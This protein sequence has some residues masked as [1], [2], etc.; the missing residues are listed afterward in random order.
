M[1]IG[2]EINGKL[3]HQPIGQVPLLEQK[4]VG[5]ATAVPAASSS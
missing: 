1:A 4:P 2:A 5:V 3:V